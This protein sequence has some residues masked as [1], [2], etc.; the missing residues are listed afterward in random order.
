MAID[1]SSTASPRPLVVEFLD[2]LQLID[3]VGI[4]GNALKPAVDPLVKNAPQ[5]AQA[6]ELL[7]E[8]LAA[9]ALDKSHEPSPVVVARQLFDDAQPQRAAVGQPAVELPLGKL[10]QHVDEQMIG[11]VLRDPRRRIPQFAARRQPA[12]S[13]VAV[14]EEVSNFGN[15]SLAHRVVRLQLLGQSQQLARLADEAEFGEPTQQV[16]EQTL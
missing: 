8:Q 9:I 6:Q 1:S 2:E 16:V 12:R 14:L 3:R 11:V 7:S 15:G 13:P 5:I 10:L 4:L